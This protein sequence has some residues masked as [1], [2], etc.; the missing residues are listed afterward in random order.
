M[1][2]RFD[3][4]FAEVMRMLDIE[5][6]ELIESNYFDIVENAIACEFGDDI[7]EDEIYKEWIYEMGK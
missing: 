6:Y 7:L 2:K 4:I 1:V 5:W 3:E